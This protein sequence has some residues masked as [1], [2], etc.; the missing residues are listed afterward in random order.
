MGR[1]R[2]IGRTKG[3][4][5]HRHCDVT[6]SGSP[7]G[8]EEGQRMSQSAR[9]PLTRIKSSPAKVR[10]GSWS[11]QIQFFLYMTNFEFRTR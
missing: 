5:F 1:I 4:G 7:Q 2:I 6:Q 9:F 8:N 10:L 11:E 3:K